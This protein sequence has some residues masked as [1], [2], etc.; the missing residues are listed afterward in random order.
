M[1]TNVLKTNSNSLNFSLWI[2]ILTSGMILFF[3]IV[4]RMNKIFVLEKGNKDV[5][6]KKRGQKHLPGDSVNDLPI[7]VRIVV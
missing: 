4:K 1:G 6:V 3:K 5:F 2:Q 7:N